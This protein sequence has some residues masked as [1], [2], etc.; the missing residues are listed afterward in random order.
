M[1]PS[2]PHSVSSA[3]HR[4]VDLRLLFCIS[5]GERWRGRRCRRFAWENVMVVVLHGRRINIRVILLS[6]PVPF[7]PGSLP[8]SKLELTHRLLVIGCSRSF[9]LWLVRSVPSLPTVRTLKKNPAIPYEM[10]FIRIRWMRHQLRTGDS[11]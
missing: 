2:F 9:R 8:Q 3:I 6:V 4:R 5:S 10:T 11:G 1:H 7:H